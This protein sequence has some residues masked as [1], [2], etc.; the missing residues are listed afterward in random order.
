[1]RSLRKQMMVTKNRIPGGVMPR[2]S[3]DAVQLVI[4]AVQ[5]S[6]SP[7]QRC[8]LALA[9]ALLTWAGAAAAQEAPAEPY[10]VADTCPFECCI[11]GEWTAL[12]TLSAREN[13]QTAAP[14]AFELGTGES[15]IAH[16]GNVVVSKLGRARVDGKLELSRMAGDVMETTAVA[17]GTIL[18]ILDSIGEGF[19]HVWY[20]GEIWDTD[21]GWMDT[22]EGQAEMLEFATTEWWVLVE[23]ADAQRG[24]LLVDDTG[25]IN[26]LD[27]CAGPGGPGILA[28]EVTLDPFRAPDPVEITN[29]ERPWLGDYAVGPDAERLL[30]L[31]APEQNGS[32][33]ISVTLNWFEELKQRVP[34]GR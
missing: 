34:T 15:F 20:E 17:P 32:D 31:V 1:M 9:V 24:W 10:T 23:N 11:Y 18:Y 30:M 13:P 3:A 33:R 12:D 25:K 8:R 28:A 27:A 22:G 7:G 16:T 19:V 29:A 6:A 5:P 4:N 21:F 14:N 26:G 2:R